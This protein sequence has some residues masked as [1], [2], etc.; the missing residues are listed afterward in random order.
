MEQLTEL[1]A[2]DADL[3]VVKSKSNAL[4]YHLARRYSKRRALGTSTCK[5]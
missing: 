3:N 4:R 2:N 1:W 5:G